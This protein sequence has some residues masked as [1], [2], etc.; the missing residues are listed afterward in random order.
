MNDLFRITVLTIGRIRTQIKT[1]AKSI[2]FS[3]LPRGSIAL[4]L[5]I[6]M[7]VN[8]PLKIMVEAMGR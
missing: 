5:N 1:E 7:Y 8:L 6:K 3:A 2:A 4:W